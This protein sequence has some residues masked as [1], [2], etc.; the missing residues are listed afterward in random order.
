MQFC[1]HILILESSIPNKERDNWFDQYNDEPLKVFHQSRD[2]WLMEREA[3]PFNYIH[4]LLN[5]RIEAA[6]NA[7]T[8]TRVRWSN[9][10]K[11][12]YLDGQAL[13]MEDRKR[14]SY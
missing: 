4:K 7:T 8:Q 13:K 9:D 2:I 1:I 3:S 5:Y 11:T 6:K 12:L 14:F 10:K